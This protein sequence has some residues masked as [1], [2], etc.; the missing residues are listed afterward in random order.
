MK[1]RIATL[2]FAGLTLTAGAQITTSADSNEWLLKES[3]RLMDE[4]EYLTTLTLLSR[5]ENSTLDARERQE[6]EY[7]RAIATFETNSLAGRALML[8]Y[9]A[10][11]PETQ[12]KGILS[13]YVAESYFYSRNFNQAIDWF[14]SCD[15]DRLEPKNEE[16]ALLHYALSTLEAGSTE[17]AINILNSIKATGKFYQSD[18]I[19]HL[20]AIDYYNDNLSSAYEGFKSIEM[21]DK[22]HLEVPY[23]LG[24]IYLKQGENVRAEKLARLF[25][26]YNSE[27]KQGTPMQQILGGALYG[28]GRYSEAIT[29]LSEY[30]QKC[31][32]PQRIAAYQLAMS[33]F[34]TEKLNEATIYFDKCTNKDD[35]I[36]QNSYLHLGIIALKLNDITNARLAFEQAAAMD[37]DSKIR[38][39]ALYNYA[40]CIHQTR[41]SP[42]AESVTV[43]ERFLNEYPDSPH[44][45]QV[46][47]YLVEVYMNTRNYDTALQ[48]IEKIE[49][50]SSEILGAKQNILY[51]LGVQSFID[52][53]MRSAIEYMNRSLA[54]SRYSV[55]THSDALYWRGEAYYRLENYQA[56]AN[57]YL[58][59]IAL[60]KRNNNDAL[61]GLAY[62]QFQNEKYDQAAETFGSFLKS[63]P[64]SKTEQRA[65]A[66]NRLGDCY[67]YNRNYTQADQFY[68]KAAETDRVH[69]DYA[70]YRSAVT[71]GL[72]KNYQDK[73]KT[74]QSL[75]ERYPSSNY[76]QQSYYEI[77]RSHVALE[78]NNEAIKAF[79]QLMKLYPESP[80]ARRAA[81]ETAI[82]YNQE[83]KQSKA[84][85][86]YKQIILKYPHSEEAQ[87]AAQDLKNIYI[88]LG[89]IS[90]FARFAESAPGMKAVESSERDTLTYAAAERIYSRQ[91]YNDALKAFN[92]YQKEFPEGSFILD[93]HYYLGVIYY[94]EKATN[95][96]LKHFEQVIAFPDNKYSEDAMAIASDIHYKAQRY[97]RA[98]E[99]YKQIVVK[100]EN[101]ERRSA[102]RMNIMRCATV[103]NRNDEAIEAATILIESGNI[104]PEWKREAL[105]TRAK[106]HLSLGNGEKAVADLTDLASDTR[107]KQGAEAKYLLAQYMFDTKQYEKCEQEILGYIES[108]TPHAYWLARSFVLLSDLYMTQGRNIE[109][110]QYLLSLQNNYSGNDDIAS[111][112]EDRLKKLA[113]ADNSQQQ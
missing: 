106:A 62:T 43:F 105:H 47:Q 27:L 111:L 113:D 67:F 103:L 45:A 86:A 4:K 81:A 101:E 9:L 40:L 46:E 32:E 71:Q 91:N 29:P 54:L 6:S 31:D 99:L 75:I 109:A 8:Q 10:D 26:E 14:K 56:A 96:A 39:E 77:G 1:K 87:L 89:N 112:I 107:S 98:I 50:P 93:S 52:N 83:G 66:Y 79:E 92:E 16:R 57:D 2:L 108:S 76:V 44:K 48:S 5:I 78:E 63:A 60:S 7:M 33:L 42:F 85:A 90:E 53:N 110:K 3:R 84:I 25:L 30:M 37:H 59:T 35:A 28:Q 36:T 17:E 72:S 73:I 94:N 13:A 22:Y 82:I 58:A 23:Y 64:T 97:E 34:N 80:L 51:R 104:S 19:F 38:E 88:E 18:A 70:L 15:F 102:C 69:S 68:K 95:E 20:A 24:G 12:K 11:Y 74:L 61:Y 65:D 21:D 100:S 49:K 41:Y 55:D